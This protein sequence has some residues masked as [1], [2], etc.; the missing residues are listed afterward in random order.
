MS[1]MQTF[2]F[3]PQGGGVLPH[4]PQGGRGFSPAN[5]SDLIV[6][7]DAALG[8]TGADVSLWEDQS[9]NGNDVSQATPGDRPLWNATDANLNNK[10]SLSFDGVSEFLQ[11]VSYVGGDIPQPNSV[12]VVYKFDDTAGT[13][14]IF[15]GKTS[16]QNLLRGEA[17]ALKMFGGVGIETIHTRNT[18]PHVIAAIFDDGDSDSFRDGIQ[19]TPAST[20]GSTAMGGLVI[21]GDVNTANFL[22]GQIAE[23]LVYNKRLS[24]SELNLLGQYLAAKYGITYTLINHSAFAASDED[25]DDFSGTLD[26]KWSPASGVGAIVAGEWKIAGIDIP[27]TWHNIVNTSITARPGYF[28]ECD[29]T[30]VAGSGAVDGAELGVLAFENGVIGPGRVDVSYNLALGKWFFD[31]TYA[32]DGAGGGGMASP[33]VECAIGT[34]YRIVLRVQHATGPGANDGI[35]W[36]YANNQLIYK[37]TDIDSDTLANIDRYFAGYRFPTVG[38]FDARWDNVK[39]GTTGQEPF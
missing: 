15:D 28:V 4:Q 11:R 14:T 24:G 12:L 21:G 2:N 32:D 23:M 29:F 8:I 18:S 38:T 31:C 30:L 20:T 33:N 35:I 3:P 6:W 13:K 9:G 36:G 22:N 27:G 10:P 34:T 17:T 16:R 39:L 25:S 1:V 5:I 37:K 26:P 19:G 7:L